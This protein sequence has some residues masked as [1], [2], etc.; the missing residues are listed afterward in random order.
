MRTSTKTSSRPRGRP[1]S[2]DRDVALRAAAARFRT[3]GFTGTSLDELVEATGLSRP[4]LYAAFG[5]KRALYLEALDRTRAWLEGQF[6]QLATLDADL[7][8]TLKAIFAPTIDVFLTGEQGASGCI[9]I[10]T[11]T[12]EA[13]HDPEIRERLA[14]IVAME[15][16]RIAA[17]L[18]RAGSPCPEAHARLVTAV[19]H[20]LSIRARAGTPREE[21][22]RLAKECSAMIAGSV[23]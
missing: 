16:T 1:R 13:V 19:I 21:L 18:A 17:A 14:E 8:G 22:V 23:A 10:N 20:S 5:D 7:P 6:A 4:S 15:D 2:F 3:H 9:V 11:A 12:V